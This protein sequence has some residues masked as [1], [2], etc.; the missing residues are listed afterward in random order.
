MIITTY[1]HLGDHVCLTAVA[2]NLYEATG[3][4]TKILKNQY[5]SIYQ[6]NPYVELAQGE[7]VKAV[8]PGSQRLGDQGNLC[9]A[10]TKSIF[11]QL[12]VSGQIKYTKPELYTCVRDTKDYVVIC[13]GYQT[14]CTVKNWSRVNWQNFI[15]NH[16]STHF[17]QVGALGLKDVQPS[18]F[19]DNL[20]VRVGK[21]QLKDLIALVAN[22][23]GVIGYASAVIHIAAAFN[24]PSIAI[25]GNRESKECTAYPNVKH[26]VN[27][28]P[29]GPCMKF[30]AGA[31]KQGKCCLNPVCIL[32]QII[33]QCMAQINIDK[34][35]EAHIAGISDR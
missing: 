19:G 14:N 35:F 22:A 29:C 11:Q 5:S 24:T 3:Q 25:I 30:Y 1:N 23:K 7:A 13:V 12:H 8:Y 26:A 18:L 27:K 21:T 33:P 4:K 28:L 34:L 9:A 17:I 2:H 15:L 32:N 31:G 6:N 10:Y 20:Q 16:P